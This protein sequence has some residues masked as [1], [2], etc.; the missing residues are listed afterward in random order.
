MVTHWPIFLLG[1][2]AGWELARALI[3]RHSRAHP[4]PAP[5]VG[6]SYE[7]RAFWDAP[8]TRGG[9]AGAIRACH[10]GCQGGVLQHP[11][12]GL[13]SEPSKPSLSVA[14]DGGDCPV[15]DLTLPHGYSEYLAS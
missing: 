9:R 10:P 8:L 4:A 15:A 5:F 6:R 13:C 7:P 12:P 1:I 3:V 14:S 11:V 2:K